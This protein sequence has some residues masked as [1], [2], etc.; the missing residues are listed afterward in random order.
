M[1]HLLIISI[2]LRAARPP[3]EEGQ[4]SQCLDENSDVIV[5]ASVADRDGLAVVWGRRLFR[6]GKSAPELTEDKP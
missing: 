3:P 4:S 6:G 5:N 1:F 2:L